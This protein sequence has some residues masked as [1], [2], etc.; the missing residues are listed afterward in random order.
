MTDELKARILASQARDKIRTLSGH[1][2]D[3]ADIMAAADLVKEDPRFAGVD[4]D[5]IARQVADNKRFW[6]EEA[7]R[8]FA[9]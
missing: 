4:V 1:S 7:R 2:R 3:E 6:E 5:A 8:Q 9:A